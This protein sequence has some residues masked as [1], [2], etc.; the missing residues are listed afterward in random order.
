MMGTILFIML[1][2]PVIFDPWWV[3]GFIDGEACFH[4][5]IVA[6]NTMKLGFSVALEFSITQHVRDI[7]LM[8]QFL[9][10]FGCGYIAKDTDSKVQFRI[11]DRSD[12]SF[13]LFPF[14]DKYPLQSVKALDYADFK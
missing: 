8:R 10:F 4:V 5:S 1:F 14:L 9:E 3:V 6:N 2:N 11:R 13:Y 12:L 7:L